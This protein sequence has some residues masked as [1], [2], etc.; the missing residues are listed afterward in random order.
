MN[1]QGFT[2]QEI[3]RNTD[4]SFTI[5]IGPRARY[6]NWLPSGGVE[7]YILVLRLYDTPVGAATRAGREARMPKIIARDCA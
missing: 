3:I 5:R 7:S 2:S 1:R 4:G 6:G